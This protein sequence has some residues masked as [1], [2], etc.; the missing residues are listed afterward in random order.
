MLNRYKFGDETVGMTL[1][2]RCK[3][4]NVAWMHTDEVG[5]QEQS[6]NAVKMATR[7]VMAI[8]DGTGVEV[9]KAMAGEVFRGKSFD[10]GLTLRGSCQ[11]G[12]CLL[13]FQ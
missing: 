13:S 10:N 12:Y 6:A 5:Y 9:E 4:V 2:F 11:G 3:R 8:S 7:V 1:E